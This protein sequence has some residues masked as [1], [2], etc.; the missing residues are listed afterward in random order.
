MLDLGDSYHAISALFIATMLCSVSHLVLKPVAS[1]IIDMVGKDTRHVN[2]LVTNCLKTTFL[3]G[4]TSS[5]WFWS[6]S[7]RA[8]VYNDWTDLVALRWIVILYTCSDIASFLTTWM[9]WSTWIHH[10]LTG[11]FAVYTCL[12]STVASHPWAQLT[13]WYGLCSTPTYLVNG[14]IASIYM[15]PRPPKSLGYYS[16]ILYSVA[17]AINWSKF[18]PT[19]LSLLMTVSWY[20][21]LVLCFGFAWIY[22]DCKLL[23]SIF[24][25]SEIHYP[26]FRK[27]VNRDE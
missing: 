9:Q 14:F 7:Y 1:E 10:L 16:I 22:D 12:S 8:F 3:F 5:Y 27:V 6:C 11:S 26:N 2:R 23:H 20:Q 4:L 15:F 13:L 18:I 25:L 19:L 21:K 24:E 17:L